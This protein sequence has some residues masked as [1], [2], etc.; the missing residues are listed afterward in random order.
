MLSILLILVYGS[1]F[2]YAI[3]RW[4]FHRYSGISPR[5]LMT[6]FGIKCLAGAFS[7]WMILRLPYE[8]DI[9]MFQRE[10]MKEYELLF[11]HPME[12]FRNFFS[13]GYAHGHAGF[14]QSG[15][16]YWNDITVNI[17]IKLL[18][19][20]NVF[21]GGDVYAN[22]IF[23]NALV[24]SG[25]I[26]WYRAFQRMLSTDGW[27][28]WVGIFLVPGALVYSSAIHKEG[29]VMAGLGWGWYALVRWL[30]AKRF[31]WKY[32]LI[33]LFASVFLVVQRNYVGLAF[34]ASMPVIVFGWHRPAR[35]VW[36]S[37]SILILGS[38]A[39]FGLRLI[40]PALD[41]PAWLAGKQAAFLGLPRGNTTID[42]PALDG[43][44]HA[45]LRVFPAALEN[46]LLRPYGA[47]I[48]QSWLLAPFWIEWWVLWIFG[49]AAMVW[50]VRHGAR[51][52]WSYF[53]WM[54]LFSLIVILIIG[55]T[56]PVLGA[57]VRYRTV[58]YPLMTIPLLTWLDDLFRAGVW[59]ARIRQRE[60]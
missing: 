24:F 34:L 18:S 35:A 6:L 58:L 12:Y 8:P 45:Y 44:F 50:Y 54:G 49:L 16:T 30:D 33:L 55:Y 13:S 23:F 15:E 31:E 51:P 52:V 3:Q 28:L 40:L 4:S 42:L 20:F 36:L 39:F 37:L 26:A 10:A 29:L 57:L 46:G 17:I 7:T 48:F 27:P 19:V 1:L 43:S 56:V 38:V 25:L 11:S 2:L 60:S 22:G 59:R 41:F 21:T 53:A 14:L 5:T 47:D 32:V 9:V